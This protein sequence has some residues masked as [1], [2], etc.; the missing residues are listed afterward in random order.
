MF[1]RAGCLPGP[2]PDECDHHNLKS[3]LRKSEAEIPRIFLKVREKYSGLP[4]PSLA[5]ICETDIG[6]FKSRIAALLTFSLMK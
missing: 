3:C 1:F 2:S 5:A 6:V 4:N